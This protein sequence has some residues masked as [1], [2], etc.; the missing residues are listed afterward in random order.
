MR[1]VAFVLVLVTLL[2]VVS[3]IAARADG[4]DL[5]N[6][7]GVVTILD[8]GISSQRSELKSFDGSSAPSGHALGYVSFWTGAFIG[9]SGSIWTGGQFSSVGSSFV[10]SGAGNYGVPRGVIFQGTF[11]GPIDW[12]M[13]AANNYFH[14]YQLTGKIQGMLWTGRT[15]SGTTTQTIYTY[16]NQLKV[17][18]QG[19]INFGTTHLATP[20]PGTLGLLGTGLVMIA[21]F[22]RRKGM[23]L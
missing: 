11:V 2:A 16:W 23:V 6:K 3:P 21:G 4:I 7:F 20:E 14:E 10:I 1:R 18:H 12:T 19:N 8:S 9:S 13:V 17:D 5:T 22:L 15:V